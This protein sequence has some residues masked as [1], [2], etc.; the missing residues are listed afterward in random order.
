MYKMI[1][2]ATSTG[3]MYFTKHGV[4]PGTLPKDVKL[5]DWRDVD[6]NVTAI[7]LDRFL[8]TREL[9]EY[10]IYP[11]TS[12]HHKMYSKKLNSC[13]ITAATPNNSYQYYYAY[14][15]KGKYR[16]AIHY[17]DV[18]DIEDPE[19]SFKQFRASVS[20]IKP[21]D[22]ADYVWARIQNGSIDYFRKGRL[23][24][25]EYY[26]MFNDYG[27]DEDELYE[28]ASDWMNDVINKACDT[29]IDLNQNVKS[30]MIYNSKAIESSDGV[31][32]IRNST[33][34]LSSS[35]FM[36]WYD[37]LSEEDQWKVD[38]MADTEGIPFYEDASDEQ[39]SWLQDQF[40]I[41]HIHI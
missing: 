17:D 32:N 9:K 27:T 25:K 31:D 20:V 28:D 1:R 7:W 21:Y 24:K 30:R 36:S 13:T 6:D 23:I 5:L 14:D 34:I 12:N 22:D 33:S 10:D 35:D 15:Y 39:L 26:F 2:T 18:T 3:Y 8:T 37:N 41:R 16:F 29:L 38:D 40:E 19:L 4:G 11:E